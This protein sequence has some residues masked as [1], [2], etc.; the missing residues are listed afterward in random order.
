MSGYGQQGRDWHKSVMAYVDH[1]LNMPQK[2]VL[3]G[4]AGAEGGTGLPPGGIIGQL[5]QK[6]VCY[7]T[8]EATTA[9]STWAAGGS[10]PSLVQNLNRIRGGWAIGDEAIR[11]RHVYWSDALSEP[12]TSGCIDAGHVPFY[13]TTGC[14]PETNVEDAI[15]YVYAN[16]NDPPWDVGDYFT[17]QT[18]TFTHDGDLEED[19][20]GLQWAAPCAM[21]IDSVYGTLNA[22]P[23]GA[24]AIIDVNKNHVSI[25][26]GSKL[27]FAATTGC[28]ATGTVVTTEL[29]ENDRVTMDIDQVGSTTAGT[30][31]VVHIRCKQSLQE[32]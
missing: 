12:G 25:L 30:S 6:Y 11:E 1:K 3:G 22:P 17:W 20:G 4:G 18:I 16:R 8:D 32:A 13:S 23:T 29:A 2:L 14:I 10:T 28:I 15:I 21:T 27:T 9:G 5:P 31:L 26:D 19:T 24:D 7:D